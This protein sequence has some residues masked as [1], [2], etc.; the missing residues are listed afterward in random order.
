MTF[1][2]NFKCYKLSFA[3]FWLLQLLKHYFVKWSLI[4]EG[5]AGFQTKIKN[6][7]FSYLNFWRKILSDFVCLSCKLDN[8]YCHKVQSPPVSSI[9]AE[10]RPIPLFNFDE[11]EIQDYK[12]SAMPTL[13]MDICREFENGNVLKE[14][15]RKKINCPDCTATFAKQMDLKRHATGVHLKLKPFHCK[16]NNCTF[17]TALSGDLKTHVDQK[18]LNITRYNCNQC[19]YESYKKSNVTRHVLDN[20]DI[21]YHCC[22]LCSKK[23]KRKILLNEHMKVHTNSV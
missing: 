3:V 8:L 22:I 1:K 15:Y 16:H 11:K 18:H 19:E 13:P 7:S 5:S 6:I 12:K 14:K 4:S 23:F 10:L 17:S 2:V 20:H 9:L 21:T